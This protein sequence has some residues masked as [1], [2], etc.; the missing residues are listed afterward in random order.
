MEEEAEA[1]DA[2]GIIGVRLD[3][4]PRARSAAPQF[5]QYRQWSEWAQAAAASAGR[6]RRGFRPQAGGRLVG[7]RD[8]SVAAVVQEMGWAQC[9]RRRGSSR[10]SRR[11]TAFGKNI[12]EFI[13][14]GTAVRI[15][16]R[17]DLPERARQAVPARPL[18]P[19][20]LDARALRLSAGRL[21]DGQL[22]L[23]R[24]A[25]HAAGAGARRASSSRRTRTRSTTRAS[26]RS[27]ACRTRPRSSAR[28]ASSA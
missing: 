28:P 14:I 19:G 25:A 13:A 22:R 27:S 4:E 20:V 23:L 9:R 2:D 3:D 26:S 24:A 15:A 16:A 18:R 8:G 17:R 7:S 6:S 1:L 12:A 10:R 5:Q 21:R 11:A